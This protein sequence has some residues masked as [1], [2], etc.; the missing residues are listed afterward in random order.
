[1]TVRYEFVTSVRGDRFVF[2]YFFYLYFINVMRE[3]FLCLFFN[4]S[5]ENDTKK[6]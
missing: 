4:L 1:M 5:S 6:I 2:R 3:W